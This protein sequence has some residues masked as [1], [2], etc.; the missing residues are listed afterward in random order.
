MLCFAPIVEGESSAGWQKKSVK[1]NSVQQICG[2]LCNWD[3]FMKCCQFYDRCNGIQ[4]FQKPQ[5]FF[6][7]I[8]GTFSQKS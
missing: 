8:H 5:I 2:M 3:D 1:F 7:Q 4:T 6:L